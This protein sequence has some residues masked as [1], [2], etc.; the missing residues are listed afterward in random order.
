MW[1]GLNLLSP[2]PDFL[3][4]ELPSVSQNYYKAPSIIFPKPLTVMNIGPL[5]KYHTA[6]KHSFV[7]LNPV[8]GGKH[9]IGCVFTLKV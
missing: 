9:A 5:D 6:I 7:L 4:M 2:N 8:N 1:P 3:P